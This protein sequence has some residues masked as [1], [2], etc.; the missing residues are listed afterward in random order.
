M[1]GQTLGKDATATIKVGAAPVSLYAQGGNMVVLDPTAKPAFS[2][3]STNQPSVK[4]KIY[5]VQ[6]HRLGAVSGI[7]PPH[8]LRRRHE[9]PDDSGKLVVNKTITIE[10]KPDEMVETRIDLAEALNGGFGN[11]IV[12]I[13]P[14]DED[15]INT[16]A[17]AFL[18][19]FR[20]HRSDLMHLLII[21]N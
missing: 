6:P 18:P 19:G 12:D 20:R 8:K 16:T 4:L 5:Q 15:A 3:Y 2:V 17:R 7:C 9:T 1:F 13:E 11:V 21:R 14:T 10:S